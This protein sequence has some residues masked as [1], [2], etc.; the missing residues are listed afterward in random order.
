M[1]PIAVNQPPD[2]VADTLLSGASPLPHLIGF[3]ALLGGMAYTTNDSS[4]M[5][6][7]A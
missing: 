3:S 4:M 6:I 2:A 7:S 5:K 1:L